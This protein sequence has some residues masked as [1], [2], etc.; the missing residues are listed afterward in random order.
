[1]RKGRGDLYKAPT[2]EERRQQKAKGKGRSDQ[3]CCLSFER[4]HVVGFRKAGMRQESIY[5]T[6]HQE[7]ENKPNTFLSMEGFLPS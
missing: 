5:K 6:V 1:M 3:V 7:T 4:W 2:M